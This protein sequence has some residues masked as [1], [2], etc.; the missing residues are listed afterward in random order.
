MHVIDI[1][2]RRP[3]GLGAHSMDQDIRGKVWIKT[4][5]GR[6]MDHDIRGKVWIRTLGEVKVWIKTLVGRYGSRH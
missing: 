6:Y 4:L 3:V 1:Q 5:G 2:E